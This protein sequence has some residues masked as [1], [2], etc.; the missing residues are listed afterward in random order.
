MGGNAAQDHTAKG[1]SCAFQKRARSG[2]SLTRDEITP[3]SVLNGASA[4]LVR[5]AL[6]EAGAPVLLALRYWAA[7][8]LACREARVL[9]PQG[10]RSA[11]A[12][13][14]ILGLAEE[15]WG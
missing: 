14:D 7:H 8:R 15:E 12:T 11:P 4:A 13:P 1:L 5:N 3:V 9:F 2:S 6:P 10:A